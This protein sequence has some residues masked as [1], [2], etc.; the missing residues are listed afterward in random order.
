MEKAHTMDGSRAI[1]LSIGMTEFAKIFIIRA[2]PIE[3][4]KTS[5]V[6][7]CASARHTYR[8]Q[9]RILQTSFVL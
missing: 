7:V 9:F 2:K 1:G 6:F 8:K 3:K 5:L 4:V